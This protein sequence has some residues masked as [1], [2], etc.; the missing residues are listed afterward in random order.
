MLL[1]RVSVTVSFGRRALYKTKDEWVVH[2]VCGCVGLDE[3]KGKAG[4]LG[5][6][7]L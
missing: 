3:M 4:S 6:I 2:P 5:A 1:I 7:I